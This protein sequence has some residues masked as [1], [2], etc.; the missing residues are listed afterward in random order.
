MGRTLLSAKQSLQLSSMRQLTPT[1]ER[2]E[3]KSLRF[4]RHSWNVFAICFAM[5]SAAMAQSVS[6]DIAYFHVN[7]VKPGMAAQYETARKHHW[8]WH[9][10]MGDTWSFH[11]WQ[12][13]SGERSG[14]YMVCSFN[15]SWKEVDESDQK[16]RGEEDDPAARVEPY[17]EAEWESYYRYLPQLSLAPEAGFSPSSK[18]AVFRFVLKPGEVNSFLLAQTRIRNA[19][20]KAGDRGTVRWYEL[21]TGGESP[22]FL[23][24]ADRADWASYEKAGTEDVDG[25]L[26]KIHGEQ[27]TAAVLRDI[28]HAVLSKYVETWQY[29]PD[30]SFVPA[31]K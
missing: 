12:I 30:L 7:R 18:L 4:L 27:Q 20:M 1:I 19:L 13:V 29:R 8:L 24:L 5:I 26:R 25:V 31:A 11:V 22:Q 10:K 9:Q 3:V 17:L 23:M 14:T 21:I 6:H 15:H 16:V 28:H 2:V